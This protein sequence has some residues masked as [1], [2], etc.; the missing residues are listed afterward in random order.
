MNHNFKRR[1]V[2]A[3][4]PPHLPSAS[5]VTIEGRKVLLVPQKLWDHFH[6]WVMGNDDCRSAGCLNGAGKG[7]TSEL[8]WKTHLQ[9]W[10]VFTYEH[11]IFYFPQVPG[12]VCLPYSVV[13]WKVDICFCVLERAAFRESLASAW[14]WSDSSLHGPYWVQLEDKLSGARTEAMNVAGDFL[15]C[16][17]DN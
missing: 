6:I 7:D 5:Q 10:E 2:I 13:T 14:Q 3:F 8:S 1:S 11:L 16:P 17:I 9:P 4:I 15:R 12:K